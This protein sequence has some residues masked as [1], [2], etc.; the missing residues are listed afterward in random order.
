MKLTSSSLLRQAMAQRSII[1]VVDTGDVFSA[2]IPGQYYIAG[3][4]YDVLIATIETNQLLFQG[5]V[6]EVAIRKD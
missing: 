6:G 3:Q 4:Y 1:P 5:P 2:A